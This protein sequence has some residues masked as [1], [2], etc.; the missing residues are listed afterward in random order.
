MSK[1]NKKFFKQKMRQMLAAAE[2][3]AQKKESSSSAV[4][5]TQET[6]KITAEPIVSTAPALSLV[7]IQIVKADLKKI[8]FVLL[9]MLLIIVCATIISDKTTWLSV[10]SDKLYSW[11]RLG[12]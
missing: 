12:S 10:I 7:P 5:T 9:V 1:K 4:E 2:G 8:A 11:S 3:T 6:K